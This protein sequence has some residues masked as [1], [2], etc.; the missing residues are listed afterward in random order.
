MKEN[1]LAI[2]YIAL[3]KY[4]IFWNNFFTSC[5]NNF[6]KE[7]DKEYFI[8]SDNPDGLDNLD[9]R[10]K[11]YQQDNLG[12][13]CSTLMRYHMFSR[14]KDLLKEYKYICYFNANTLFIKTINADEFFGND[15]HE[16]IGGLHPGYKNE[17]KDKY[18]FERRESSNAFTRNKNY[19]FQ[20]CINGGRS[21]YFLNAIDD[22]KNNII[23]DINQGI[24]A[25][26]HDESHWNSYLN[27]KIQQNSNAVKIL[28]CNYLWPEGL[29]KNN[30]LK[31]LMRDKKLF[32]GHELLRGVEKSQYQFYLE[33][34]KKIKLKI[35][36]LLK[37]FTV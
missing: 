35:K 3:G 29:G 11:F 31:I 6:C 12:W 26:W 17:S 18:P 21:K 10:I 5:E 8:F 30:D 1:S 25:I 16:L 28:G 37:I 4:S 7:L 13:P 24:V 23:E 34:L 9:A 36:N 19:Y 22:L 20:G 33:L 2:L 14:A 27:N 32:G 15:R